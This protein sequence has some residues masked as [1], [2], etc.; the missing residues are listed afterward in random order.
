MWVL[1][2]Q[3]A[4]PCSHWT[5]LLLPRTVK[6]EAFFTQSG[7]SCAPTLIPHTGPAQPLSRRGSGGEAGHRCPLLPVSL[8]ERDSGHCHMRSPFMSCRSLQ[9]WPRPSRPPPGHQQRLCGG[10]HPGALLC[11]YSVRV[12]LLPLQTQV[13]THFIWGDCWR[14][15]MCMFIHMFKLQG[16]TSQHPDHWAGLISP[17]DS[18]LP[19]YTCGS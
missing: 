4:L 12:C 2:P 14:K 5:S 18:A 6:K 10:C 7:K 11:S 13:K 16:A 1:S 17:L 3:W 15:S 8:S 9:Q 19:P